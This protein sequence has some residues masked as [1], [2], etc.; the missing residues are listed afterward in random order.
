MIA[1]DSL[2]RRWAP[3]LG[4]PRVRCAT[5]MIPRLAA[6]AVTTT[7]VT[8]QSALVD[9]RSIVADRVQTITRDSVWKAVA[10]IP[11]AFRTFHPQGMVKIGDTFF[12]SSVEVTTRTS[13][14]APPQGGYDRDAG[15]GVGHLFKI[16]E[17]GSELADLRLG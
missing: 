14:F 2:T 1:A 10:T 4:H 17:S 16:D 15:A 11:I 6:L 9:T 3:V 5:G 12:V 13:P 7:V 8:A